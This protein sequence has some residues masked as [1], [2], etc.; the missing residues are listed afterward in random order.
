MIDCQIMLTMA[1]RAHAA[2]SEAAAFAATVALLRH[3]SGLREICS[4][5]RT[6]DAIAEI[7]FYTAL[8]QCQARLARLAAP[9]AD[10][11]PESAHDSAPEAVD[12]YTTVRYMEH[13]CVPAL[14]AALEAAEL[15]PETLARVP[16]LMVGALRA[17]GLDALAARLHAALAVAAPVR[18]LQ[19]MLEA[20]A[21]E[22][23]A[24]A[25]VRAAAK[26]L[27][28]WRGGEGGEG[29]E[30]EAVEWQLRCAGAHLTRTVDAETDSRV[31]FV[32]DRWQVRLMSDHTLN[33][34]WRT[35]TPCIPLLR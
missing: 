6:R 4:A 5:G 17:A 16:E 28:K 23:R 19:E 9:L 21:A 10:A 30:A 24:V 11:A 25:E 3:E 26:A 32:P 31:E 18:R 7:E 2:G 1:T 14:P 22:K 13:A 20:A 12:V 33:Q 27:R 34:H 15:P 35:C 29:A 8:L